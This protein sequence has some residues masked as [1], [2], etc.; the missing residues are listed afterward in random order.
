M[1][2][3]NLL[4]GNE[5][6]L[7]TCDQDANERQEIKRTIIVTLVLLLWGRLLGRLPLLRGDGHGKGMTVS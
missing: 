3:E 1:M 2:M 7:E 4:R 5:Q 6:H